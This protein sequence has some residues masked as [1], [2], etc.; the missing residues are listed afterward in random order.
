[1]TVRGK[2]DNMIQWIRKRN[3]TNGTKVEES[4][5]LGEGRIE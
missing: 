5:G 3:E 4:S 2:K 1:M